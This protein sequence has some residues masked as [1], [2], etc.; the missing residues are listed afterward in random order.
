VTGKLV[1]ENLKHRPMRSLLSVLLI[2]IP[3]T[4]I[5]SLVGLSH[6]MLDTA[7]QRARGIGA[8]IVVRPKGSSL[9]TLGAS[10]SDKM[11]DFFATQPHV[12]LTMGVINVAVEN[13]TLGATGVDLALFNKMSG[14]FHY[15]EGGP[16]R[17]PDDIIVDEYYARQHNL[18][19]GSKVNVQN[20]DWRVCG[21]TEGGT[22]QRLVLPLGVLQ[23]LTGQEHKVSQVYL[24]LDKPANTDSVVRA[25]KAIPE[26][27]GWPIFS[28]EEF[29]SAYNPSNVPALREF[30]FIVMGIGVI[31]GF[32]VVCLS[33]YMAVLQRTREIGILKSLGSS[34]GFILRII[35]AE[36]ALLGAGGTVLGVLMSM[37]AWWIIRTFYPASFPMAIVPSWWPI[38]GAITLG[39][40]LLGALYPGLIAAAHDPIEALAY[41]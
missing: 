36:A 30:T 37:G 16:F 35:L 29:T 34:K 21:I 33:M 6:G 32:A 17:N 19:V 13:V 39:G 9:L 7:A 26:L 2:G 14:G 15:R 23:N 25:L 31:I 27:D 11:V 38:A 1:L 3:V 41:E 18:K 40:T 28:I 10:F 8:D 20:R 4:L 22:L 12:I 24:K 5:L